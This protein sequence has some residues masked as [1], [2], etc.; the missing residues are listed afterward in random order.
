MNPNFIHLFS[1]NKNI[2]IFYNKDVIVLTNLNL[3]HTV[4]NKNTFLYN[5]FFLDAPKKIRLLIQIGIKMLAFEI[6]L[7]SSKMFPVEIKILSPTVTDL[8]NLNYS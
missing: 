8:K 5:L 4:Q 1:K 6:T 7:I 2:L 3:N